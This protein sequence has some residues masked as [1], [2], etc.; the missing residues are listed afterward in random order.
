MAIDTSPFPTGYGAPAQTPAMQQTP[1]YLQPGDASTPPGA[2]NNMVRALMS[3]YQD[4]LRKNPGERGQPGAAGAGMPGAPMNIQ[5][6]QQ[7]WP[8]TGATSGVPYTGGA[9][10]MPGMGGFM[11]MPGMGGFMDKFTGQGGMGNA[12]FNKPPGDLGAVF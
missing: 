3:G 1:S 10:G 12:L 2:V 8:P 5:S 11:S 7:A 6:P 9:A 4:Y